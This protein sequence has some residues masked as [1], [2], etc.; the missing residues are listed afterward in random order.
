[1][2]DALARFLVHLET[3][4]R[5]SP[6]TR[7]AYARDIEDFAAGIER[8]RDRPAKVRDL[9]V[10][11]VRAALAELH[12]DKKAST[13]GRK[14]SA[15]RTFGEFCRREGLLEENEVALIRR[16]KLGRKLPIALPVEDL[17]AMIDGPQREGAIGLRDK[18]LLEVLYGA[19]LRVSEAVGLDVD[20]LRWE[21]SRL[22]VRVV[23]GKGGKDRVVPLGTRAAKALREWLEVRDDIASPRS[24][25]NAIFL[26]ARGGRLATR[27]AREVVYR[28]CQSTGARAVVGPHGLRH[29]FATHLLQS[30]CDLRTI[31]SMLGHASLST[32]QRYT[33]LDMG[34]LFELYEHSHPRASLAGSGGPSL[35]APVAEPPS[36]PPV[37]EKALEP[38]RRVR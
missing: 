4:R 34:R 26:G 11:E 23:G 36:R 15:L 10:R 6:N 33:H 8:R 3:E 5:L 19:G 27:V 12:G 29:S 18:A 14:L 25:S 28:R 32:T 21:G 35:D 20:H 17:S 38:L 37:A 13:I 9:N 24:P 2:R 30:G 1:M 22:M 31:Q 7:R 16:P